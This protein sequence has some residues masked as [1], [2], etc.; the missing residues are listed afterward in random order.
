[1][2]HAGESAGAVDAGRPG[3]AGTAASAGMPAPASNA[4]SGGTTAP[5]AALCTPN[6]LRCASNQQEVCTAD[7][8][9]WETRP[10]TSGCDPLTAQCLVCT[11]G[12]TTCESSTVKRCRPDGSGFEMTPC[13]VGC[14]TDQPECMTCSPNHHVCNGMCSDST[15]PTTCGT[16]CEPC[17]TVSNAQATCVEG[18]CD[19]TCNAD[20]LRCNDSSRMCEKKAWSFESD[21]QGWDSNGAD[22]DAAIGMPTV[23]SAR[24]HGGAQALSLAFNVNPPRDRVGFMYWVCGHGR[25]TAE[26]KS[27]NALGKTLQAWIYIEAS[28]SAPGP[29]T[30]WISASDTQRVD[31]GPVPEVMIQSGQWV[32]LR[33]SLSAAGAADVMGFFMG[34][35]FNTST[36]WRGTVYVDDI[37]LQ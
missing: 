1:M 15:S 2:S 33:T 8:R 14:R 35:V 27:L 3:A 17:E 13:V 22:D 18:R 21:L 32:A 16:R 20:S 37:S 30:C 7:G 28:G 5:S 11:P 29:S 23:S 34:C 4:G 26:T 24:K 6:A 19:F 36:S 31:A 10:C 25:F 12:K 9:S